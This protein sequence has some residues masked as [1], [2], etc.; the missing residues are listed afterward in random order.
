ME[1]S[2]KL[3]GHQANQ[4]SEAIFNMFDEDKSGRMDF[5]EYMMVN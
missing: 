1:F 5:L 4:L 2:R 3:Y